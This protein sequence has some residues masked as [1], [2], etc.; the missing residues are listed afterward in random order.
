MDPASNVIAKAKAYAG[1][2]VISSLVFNVGMIA[3]ILIHFVVSISEYGLGALLE[4]DTFDKSTGGKISA[5]E[6]LTSGTSGGAGITT[7]TAFT[8]ASEKL[9]SFIW[10]LFAET[11]RQHVFGLNSTEMSTSSLKTLIKCLETFVM[12][13][14][15]S[16]EFYRMIVPGYIGKPTPV[17]N[18]LEL[19]ANIEKLLAMQRLVFGKR[20][21]LNYSDAMKVLSS[22]IPLSLE[23]TLRAIKEGH[24]Q[25]VAKLEHESKPSSSSSSS[26]TSYSSPKT[27][28]QTPTSAGA[29]GLKALAEAA[30]DQ[31]FSVLTAFQNKVSIMPAAPKASEDFLM[32]YIG[33]LIELLQQDLLQQT[34]VSGESKNPPTGVQM[35]R[36][37]T[38]QAHVAETYDVHAARTGTSDTTQLPW[39]SALFLIVCE[40]ITKFTNWF[41]HGARS[42]GPRC[43]VCSLCTA[44]PAAMKP[45]MADATGTHHPKDCPVISAVRS[46]VEM[47][48]KKTFEGH[49]KS[50]RT[51]LGNLGVATDVKKQAENLASARA[52]RTEPVNL[53]LLAPISTADEEQTEHAYVAQVTF[54]PEV[55]PDLVDITFEDD[56]GE[57]DIGTAFLQEHIDN[58]NTGYYCDDIIG[59]AGQEVTM[60]ATIPM[61]NAM[62]ALLDSGAS[63]SI[64]NPATVQ[65]I[66]NGAPLVLRPANVRIRGV[67]GAVHNAMGRIF[68][69]L[70]ANCVLD[71]IVMQEA[72]NII[73]T[74]QLLDVENMTRVLLINGNEVFYV[75]QQ[76]VLH[77]ERRTG[78]WVV[79]LDNPNSVIV[80][81]NVNM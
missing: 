8:S 22:R 30:S 40:L 11:I 79:N 55:M 37:G 13:K 31:E 49:V 25:R 78:L 29:E 44:L 77:A 76:Q 1:V 38:A 52:P 63:V 71:A 27:E 80:P 73:S 50:L 56:S 24:E 62:D 69:R 47:D 65:R 36:T 15:G 10:N 43:L 51:V 5:E 64:L 4:H 48:S 33:V 57:H 3:M 20:V 59:G 41:G 70:G 74:S 26:S 75:N 72:Q 67:N 66:L 68:I 9:K 34:V 58:N 6:Q 32:K 23:R 60:A 12:G 81:F 53:H 46:T 35:Y 17:S 7:Q 39:L 21:V 16:E 42:N 54:D 28:S 2:D 18:T 45:P 61:V 19:L 14:V